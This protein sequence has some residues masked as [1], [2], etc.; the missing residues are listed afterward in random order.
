MVAFSLGPIHIYWYGIF[1]AVGFLVAYYFLGYLR[2]VTFLADYAPRFYRLLLERREDIVLYAILGVL[3]GGRLGDVF[4]YNLGYYLQHPLH[5]F[6]VWEGGM[7]FIG[8]IIGVVS[9]SLLL[10]WKSKFS[11]RDFLVMMDCLMLP[12]VFS[13]MI[14]RVG[15]F[16]NQELYWIPVPLHSLPLSLV[17]FFSH[18]GIFYVY[19]KVDA[20]LR[21]NT[22]M[23]ASFGEGFCLLLLLWM[24]FLRSLQ[25]KNRSVGLFSGLFLMGYSLVRFLLE[26]L[27]A[28]SQLEYVYGLT[29]SQWFFVLFFGIWILFL[30][31]RKKIV[32]LVSK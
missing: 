22:N 4:I 26:Y 27:R 11:L 25:K 19:S 32:K 1:Y 14:W 31:F 5:V 30:I 24:L 29:K 18:V 8:W 12:V 2:K 16:L 28:D 20:L 23:L 17:H 21:F 7:S 10:A 9:A 6:A 15:N 13:I 3:I